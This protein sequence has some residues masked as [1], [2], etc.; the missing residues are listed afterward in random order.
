[1]TEADAVDDVHSIQLHDLNIRGVSN[2]SDA[3]HTDFAINGKSVLEYVIG[4]VMHEEIHRSLNEQ[5][6]GQSIHGI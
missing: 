5:L 4:Y 6:S 3:Q 2:Q 1:M